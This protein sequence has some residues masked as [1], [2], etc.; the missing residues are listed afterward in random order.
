MDAELKHSNLAEGV[1]GLATD[2]A[3]C[4]TVDTRCFEVTVDKDQL[5][6]RLDGVVKLEAGGQT[7]EQPLTE[8]ME[9]TAG[10]L[11]FRF[12]ELPWGSTANISVILEATEETEE[13]VLEVL[14]DASLAEAKDGEIPD[15]GKVEPAG[16]SAPSPSSGA[17]NKPESEEEDTI[18]L[19]KGDGSSEPLD[20]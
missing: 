13:V 20:G 7:F 14:K 12:F 19:R 1:S 2:E 18:A 15:G 5:D 11:C 6:E 8:G 10:V 17:A 4:I 3:H 16:T 9:E